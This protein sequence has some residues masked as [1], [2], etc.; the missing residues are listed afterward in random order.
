LKSRGAMGRIPRGERGIERKI[1]ERAE[2][3][4]VFL[5]N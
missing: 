3:R 1:E 2:S 4:R 5:K